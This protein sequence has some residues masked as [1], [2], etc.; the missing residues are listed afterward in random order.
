MS[1]VYVAELEGQLR[2]DTRRAELWQ[3][4]GDYVDAAIRMS[5]N[6][7]ALHRTRLGDAGDRLDALIWQI[8]IDVDRAKE[9][10]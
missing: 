1:S 6:F 10:R 8:L 5:E 7:D 4:I 9:A 3:A 2:R